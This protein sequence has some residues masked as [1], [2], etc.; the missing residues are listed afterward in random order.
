LVLLGQTVPLILVSSLISSDEGSISLLKKISPFF[1][2]LFTIVSVFVSINHSGDYGLAGNADAN[3][4]YQKTSYL[5]AY[6]ASLCMYFILNFN[7]FA[8]FPFVR[9]KIVKLV[10]CVLLF[11][12]FLTTLMSGGRGGVMTFVALIILF[13][14]LKGKKSSSVKKIIFYTFFIV[15]GIVLIF[16]YLETNSSNYGGGFARLLLFVQEG[17][18]SGRDKL[19]VSA[20]KWISDSPII[21]HG[22]GSV[23]F[24]LGIFSHNIFLD[25]LI[26]TGLLGLI[27]FLTFIFKTLKKGISLLKFNFSE[28]IWLFLFVDGFVMDLFSDYYIGGFPWISAFVIMNYRY[29]LHKSLLYTTKSKYVEN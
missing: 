11:V 4:D 3:I 18:S 25:I 28:S 13:I 1:A 26:E 20:L 24:T 6:A 29:L 7:N 21:G 14:Y 16:Q 15:F 22:L 5:A 23:F 10:F 12:N 19:L 2:I 9:K 8:W 27:V 17:D